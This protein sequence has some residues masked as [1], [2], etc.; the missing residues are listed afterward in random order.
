M[1]YSVEQFKALLSNERGFASANMYRV[2]LPSLEGKQK[3]DGSVI[4][5]YTPENLNLLCKATALPGRQILTI[6]R[7]IGMV[8]TKVAYG[9]AVEN[10]ALT[11]QCTNSYLIR[12]YFQDWQ[13]LAISNRD[14]L[15]YHS[16]YFDD[17][18]QD[19]RIAQIRKPESFA[20]RNFDLGFDLGLD[21]VVRD[22][23]PTIGGVDLGDLSEGRF[24]IAIV[25]EEN[26][27]HE[28][29]LRK[30]FPVSMTETS[31]TN[32]ADQISEFTV[33]LA[34]KNWFD[35]SPGQDNTLSDEIIDAI[36]DLAG[37]I[38]SVIGSFFD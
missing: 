34:Y 18:T 36:N 4:E 21:P 14:G 10:V 17:Y 16:G 2:I 7:Q 8:N 1:S 6:D 20:I 38:G 28:C 13:Q 11:F 22:A 15:R 5:G 32:E 37:S 26:I 25:S 9:F 31:L 27:V 24:D 29:L 12:R 3:M 35:V 33:A 23:L 19:V 30:A